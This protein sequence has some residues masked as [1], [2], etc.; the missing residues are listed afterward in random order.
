MQANRG[1][2]SKPELRVRS[3]LHRAGLRFRV[4]Q[5]LPF[6]RRRRADITF[7]RVHLYVFIDG[8]YWHGCPEH[9]QTPKTNTE[10]WTGKVQQNQIRDRD[11]TSELQAL[12]F[13]V[14]RFWEHE[15][16]D[17]VVAQIVHT[18]WSLRGAAQHGWRSHHA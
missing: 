9:Y 6:D 1:R 15:P 2:D 8:C 3:A 16:P 14:L 12:G 17:A 10:F 4:C 13:T 11:T 7:P 18:Y 5:V